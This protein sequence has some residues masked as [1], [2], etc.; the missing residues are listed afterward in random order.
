MSQPVGP[1]ARSREPGPVEKMMA[2]DAA[3]RMLGM[4]LL[5]YGDGWARVR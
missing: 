2:S 4:E 5:D 1:L 3:S